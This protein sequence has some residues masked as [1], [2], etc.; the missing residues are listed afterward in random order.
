MKKKLLSVCLSGA[1]GICSVLPVQASNIP[2]D[3][4]TFNRIYEQ[5]ESKFESFFELAYPDVDVES[6]T[7]SNEYD[8]LYGI[9][10]NDYF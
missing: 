1:I 9:D 10:G 4:E 2:T 8:T 3:F 7:L 6:V 5:A